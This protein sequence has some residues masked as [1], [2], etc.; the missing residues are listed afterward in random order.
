MIKRIGLTEIKEKIRM[1]VVEGINPQEMFSVP[2]QQIAR[3][4]VKHE[5]ELS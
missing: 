5:E 4:Y 3:V 1:A 2:A